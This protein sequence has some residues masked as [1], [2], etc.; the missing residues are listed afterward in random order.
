MKLRDQIQ[1]EIQALPGTLG[2]LFGGIAAAFG[3]AGLA[4]EI[5]HD[6]QNVFWFYLLVMLCGFGLFIR[7]SVWLDKKTARQT[8]TLTTPPKPQWQIDLLAWS[9][10]FGFAAL[11]LLVVY[12]IVYR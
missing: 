2:K 8:E 12:F 7:S 10:F 9:L 3:V 5:G 6:H 4:T 11:F 1:L